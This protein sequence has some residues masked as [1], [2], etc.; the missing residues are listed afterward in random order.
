[1]SRNSEI[2]GK[3]TD[4]NKRIFD[5]NI[6][7]GFQNLLRMSRDLPFRIGICIG[8]ILS[9]FTVVIDF[10]VQMA[11]EKVYKKSAKAMREGSNRSTKI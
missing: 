11:S 2:L 5:S 1:M 8:T 7:G 4:G 6:H 9:Y 3:F 10:T